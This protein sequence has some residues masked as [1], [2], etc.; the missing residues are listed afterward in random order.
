MPYGDIG[1][2]MNKVALGESGAGSPPFWRKIVPVNSGTIR[3]NHLVSA[4]LSL[5]ARP[6][7]KPRLAGDSL[8][9]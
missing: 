9:T 6:K 3:K 4:F 7:R 1:K 2:I 8:S 5:G